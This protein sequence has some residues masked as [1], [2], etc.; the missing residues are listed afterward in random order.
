MISVSWVMNGYNLVLAVLFLTMGRLADRYGHKR[1]FVL[2]LTL[3]TVASYA[4]ARAGSIDQLIAFRVV[5][6]VG[7]AAVIPTALVLMLD[8][9][10]GRPAGVRSRPVRGAQLRRRGP[11]AGARRRPHRALGLAGDLL[12]Q[13]A[14]RSHRHRPGR[15][16]RPWPAQAP[17]RRRA[18]LDR[19]RPQQRRPL[20]P[21]PGA[22]RG[23]RLGM[24]ERQHP[25][26][27]R[28]GGRVA[29]RVRGLGA[30]HALPA[31]RPPPLPRPHLRG[32]RR[33][34]S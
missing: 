25:R 22:H 29:R 23:Q 30:A 6:A 17:G 12:A 19:R 4:C 15:G 28:G 2:G 8:A 1:L 3:F 33:R 32:G 20:L 18:R 16:P 24:D 21:H 31:L 14:G 13:R 11:R 9:F 5:Q 27:V 26:L 34:P 7:A 10:P